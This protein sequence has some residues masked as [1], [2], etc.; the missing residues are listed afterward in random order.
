MEAVV[1]R[2]RM[3]FLERFAGAAWA[4]SAVFAGADSISKGYAASKVSECGFVAYGE[5]GWWCLEEWREGVGGAERRG[6][7]FDEVDD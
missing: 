1:E 3:A 5:E 6:L 4:R 7:A 2:E